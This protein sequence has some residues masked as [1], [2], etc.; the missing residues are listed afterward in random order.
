MLIETNGTRLYVQQDSEAGDPLLLLHFGMSHLGVWERVVPYLTDRYRVVRVDLRGHGRS[1]KPADGYTQENMGRDI[2]GVMDHLGIERA[3]LV[4]SSMGAEVAA[5]LAAQAQ[6]R[7]ISLALEGAFQNCFGRD[8]IYGDASLAEAKKA[9][10]RAARAARPP[11]V[12]D[13]ADEALAE[14]LRR[15]GRPNDEALARAMRGAIGPLP[16]GRYGPLSQPYVQNA[17]MEAFW[18]ARFD[19]F[20]EAINCPV[21]FLPD[22]ESA[23]DATTQASIAWFRSLLRHSAVVNIPGAQHAA[24]VVDQPERFARAVMQFHRHVTLLT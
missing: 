19:Q 24:V 7:V 23:G 1:D 18:D 17:Y 22:A 2:L 16:D 8:S 20:Y 14:W 12:G 13:T 9:E 4:G 5:A 15:W 21:L 10:L 11:A 6:N 3:H